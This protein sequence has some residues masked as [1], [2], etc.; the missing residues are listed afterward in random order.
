MSGFWAKV[1][2]N[3]HLVYIL[4]TVGVLSRGKA[5]KNN[6][7]ALI[8]YLTQDPAALEWVEVPQMR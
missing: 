6:D 3:L 2:Q 5:N 8:G 7:L 1:P 4:P